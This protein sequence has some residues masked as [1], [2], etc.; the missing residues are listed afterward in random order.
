LNLFKL[1]NKEEANAQLEMAIF[2]DHCNDQAIA[3]FEKK[4]YTK[5]YKRVYKNFV[6]FIKFATDEESKDVCSVGYWIDY[7]EYLKSPNEQILR[8][9]IEK[10]REH[11]F[12]YHLEAAKLYLNRA[13]AFYN[14]NFIDLA[15]NDLRKAFYLD[16]KI[17]EKEYY[18][19]IERIINS[20]H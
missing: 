20:P 5:E 6:E 17:K 15:K 1:N 2:Q 9:I 13:I 14:L 8:T 3:L 11:H 19:A 18:L 4:T 16:S 10:I 12:N 7:E